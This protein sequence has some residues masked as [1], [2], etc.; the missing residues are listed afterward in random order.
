VRVMKERGRV[1]AGAEGR[2][3][4]ITIHPSALL[5]IQ[6]ADELQVEYRRFVAD[7]KAIKRWRMKQAA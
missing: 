2:P 5:L 4:F 1:E 3:V 7:M 6:D